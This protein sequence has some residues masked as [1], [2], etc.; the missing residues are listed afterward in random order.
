MKAKPERYATVYVEPL[1]DNNALSRAAHATPYE[2]AEVR[3]TVL[4]FD[5]PARHIDCLIESLADADI[6]FCAHINN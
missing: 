2:P 5:L 3:G 6:T 4:I 1:G